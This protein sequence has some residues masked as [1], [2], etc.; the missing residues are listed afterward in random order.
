[1]QFKDALDLMTS[2]PILCVKRPEFQGIYGA[3]IPSNDIFVIDGNKIIM[4]QAKNSNGLSLHD[5][6]IYSSQNASILTNLPNSRS[7][8]V[9]HGILGSVMS[10]K[11]LSLT[12]LLEKCKDRPTDLI[13]SLSNAE[14]FTKETLKVL[15]LQEELGHRMLSSGRALPTKAS[16]LRPEVS[17]NALVANKNE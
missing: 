13:Q 1:M 6:V 15:Y 8:L 17:I 2:D 11:E 4:I 10:I 9:E 3:F 16:K 12:R 7:L 5:T 14:A